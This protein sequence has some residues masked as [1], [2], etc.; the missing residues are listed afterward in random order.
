MSSVAPSVPSGLEREGK[1]P[2]ELSDR[3]RAS[4][5][6]TSSIPA[7][8]CPVHR[9][10][11]LRRNPGLQL[12]GRLPRNQFDYIPRVIVFT[13]HLSLSVAFTVHRGGHGR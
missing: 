2:R 9:E 4:A 10:V 5:V 8:M 3:T 13:G 12:S 11:K 7:G 1:A 6:A